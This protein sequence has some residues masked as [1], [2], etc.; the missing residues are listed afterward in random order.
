MMQQA[1][2]L[3]L[4][5]PFKTYENNCSKH[6]C[7]S[8]RSLSPPCGTFALT[9]VDSPCDRR[10]MVFL[11]AG[12]GITP[13]MSMIESLLRGEDDDGSGVTLVQCCRGAAL[14]PM[15]ARAEELARTKGMRWGGRRGGGMK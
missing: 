5:P 12:V 10:P 3:L 2:E 4:T 7:F 14:H 8:P 1:S 9:P 13:L 11:S 15:A 6:L